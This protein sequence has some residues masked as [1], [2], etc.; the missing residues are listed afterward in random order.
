M[1]QKTT[2][3]SEFMLSLESEAHPL[4]DVFTDFLD[5]LV[6]GLT[7]GLDTTASY[8]QILGK[9][10]EEEA[11]MFRAALIRF[12][13]E[14]EELAETNGNTDILGGFYETH[15]CDG[16][17]RFIP[18]EACKDMVAGLTAMEIES[19]QRIAID[20]RCGSGRLMLAYIQRF[21]VARLTL[22]IE[23]NPLLAKITAVNLFWRGAFIGEVMC[24]DMFGD[25][26]EF[27]F[28]YRMSLAPYG[29][30]PIREQ[31]MSRLWHM[32]RDILVA[33]MDN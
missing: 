23:S 25:D 1:K 27:R 13:T 8:R 19:M 15:L 29:L 11:L 4:L 31:N 14:F 33:L 5:L 30:I 10:T 28:S 21:G 2:T 6:D 7:A 18:W 26:D 16:E 32:S 9:Y 20:P 3:F 22:G 17:Q 12:Q 24:A